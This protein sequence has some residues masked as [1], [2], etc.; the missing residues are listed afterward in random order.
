MAATDKQS[1][2]RTA[3]RVESGSNRQ[4]SRDVL[5]PGLRV[6]ATD[7]QSI[8]RTAARV[9]SGSNRQTIYRE[10]CCQG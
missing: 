9:E 2:E 1:I 10:N 3:A 8:E 4:T 7:R 5:L 6:A